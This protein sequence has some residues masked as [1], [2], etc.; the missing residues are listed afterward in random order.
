MRII[1][2]ILIFLSESLSGQTIDQT[3]LFIEGSEVVCE[4][5]KT[6]LY[7]SINNKESKLFEFRTFELEKVINE[8]R[9]WAWSKNNWHLFKLDQDKYQLRKKL[10]DFT[11]EIPQHYKYLID[12]SQWESPTSEPIIKI[13]DIKDNAVPKPK[14]Y[15]IREDGNTTF[16]LKGKPNA[17]QV[18]LSGSFNNWNEQELKMKWKDD[19]WTLIL[20][21]SPGI[22][23]YKFIID[24]EW[25]HDVKNPYTVVNQHSTLN[26]ILLVG[27]KITFNLDGYEHAKKVILA[28]S[29]N[30]WNEE[31]SK[32]I[33]TNNGW[34][35]TIS[36]PP[37]KHF[38]KFIVDGKWLPDPNN[39]LEQRDKDGNI[40]SVKLI[41]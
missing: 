4:F 12:H 25:I 19:A 39:H 36:L 28:G 27:S 23:E 22:Y 9:S 29:F 18:I 1:F 17:K 16:Q 10:K 41:H 7:S 26:S 8:N 21:L 14:P 15:S 20:D 3:K 11:G 13:S 40:N 34:Q 35:I 38:Y 31:A 32:M 2:L 24:G 30:N 5:N 37:G 6:D 33:K